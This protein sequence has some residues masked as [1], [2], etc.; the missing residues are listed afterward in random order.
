MTPSQLD[1]HSPE[2]SRAPQPQSA[3]TT[4]KPETILVVE[5]EPYVLALA[6]QV[7]QREGYIVLEAQDGESALALATTRALPIDL[8]LTDVV[9][10]GLCGRELAE[11]LRPIHPTM[12]VLFVSG[13]MEDVLIRDGIEREQFAFLAKPYMIQALT[14]KV[15]AVLDGRGEGEGMSNR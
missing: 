7:L 3:R 5:D 9:M 10:P 2:P 15:R 13:Y 6:R 8:L 11:K 14:E 1:P 12:K 4:A